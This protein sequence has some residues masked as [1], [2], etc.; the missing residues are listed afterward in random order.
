MTHPAFRAALTGAVLLIGSATAMAQTS[1]PAQEPAATPTVQEP[2]TL[3][4]IGD[5][6]RNTAR[7][8]GEYISWLIPYD[9]PQMQPNGDILIRRDRPAETTEAAPPASPPSLGQSTT[10]GA[11]RL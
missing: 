6:V 4:K 10:D 3:E 1:T 11:V 8:A 7:E 9:L 2:T 5:A